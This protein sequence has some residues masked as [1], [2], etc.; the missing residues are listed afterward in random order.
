M[1]LSVFVKT[2][3]DMFI[4]LLSLELVAN[5]KKKIQEEYAFF[6]HDTIDCRIKFNGQMKGEYAFVGARR[7]EE[8]HTD[9]ERAY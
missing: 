8:T 1:K 4:T 2:L 5:L 6:C 7:K 3:P 9:T